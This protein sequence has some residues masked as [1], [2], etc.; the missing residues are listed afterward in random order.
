MRFQDAISPL[1]QVGDPAERD[2]RPAKHH[3][4]AVECH[5]LADRHSS[6]DHR[7]AAQPEDEQRS[8][9]HE[10]SHARV[11]HPLQTDEGAIPAD[12]LLVRLP[13]PLDLGR[14]LAVRAHDPDACQRFLRHGADVGE[15]LLDLFETAVNGVAE[16]ADRQRDKRRRDERHDRQPGVDRHHDDD[17]DDER[18]PRAC[19]VHHGGADHHSDGAQIVRRPRHQVTR[20][21]FVEVAEMLALELREEVVSEVV[22]ELPGRPDDH[23]AHQE[24]EDSADRGEPEQNG[25]VP[26]KLIGRHLRGEIVDRVFEDPRSGERDRGHDDDTGE[27]AEKRATVPQHVPQQPPRRG[28]Q[29]RVAAPDP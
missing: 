23:A 8:S 19:R 14:L 24:P 6:R 13:E 16:V 29:R 4:I 21:M 18:E 20:A 15:L 1:Q 2:H 17:C 12:V 11:V 3:E 22:L 28:H 5:Q 10:Q 26:P 27:P 25:R 7:A 9:A